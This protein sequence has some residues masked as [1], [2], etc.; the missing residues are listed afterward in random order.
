V[1]I[2]PQVNVDRLLHGGPSMSVVAE[3]VAVRV[4]VLGFG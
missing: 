3:V 1:W 4:D 2:R